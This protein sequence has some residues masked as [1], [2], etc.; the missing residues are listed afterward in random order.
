MALVVT[1]IG[2]LIHVYSTG[3]MH[4]DPRLPTLLLLPEPVHPDDA[5]AGAGQ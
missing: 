3:Y 4:D 5:D 2:F 1:G